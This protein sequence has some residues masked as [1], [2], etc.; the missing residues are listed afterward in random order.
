MRLAFPQLAPISQALR[1]MSSVARTVN[2]NS[3]SPH[4]WQDE[5]GAVSLLG[6]VT[7]HLLSIS[8]PSGIPSEGSEAL[9]V[10][11]LARLACLTIL[12]GL[13]GLFSLNTLDA[14]PLFTKFLATV[15]R[16][17]E[18]ASQ[19]PDIK[20]WALISCAL[21]QTGNGARALLPHIQ[22][23]LRS[24]GGSNARCAINLAKSLIWID[25]LEGHGEFQL[26]RDIDEVVP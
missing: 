21:L 23:A 7:H 18:K 14:A 8:R 26:T 22:A 2:R 9:V 12:S 13:K 10:G 19:L 17:P 4:F 1:I 11:E 3:D 15:T 25:A 24:R 16:S 5:I 20:L 6:P